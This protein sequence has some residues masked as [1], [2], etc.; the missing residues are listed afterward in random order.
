MDTKEIIDTLEHR[1]AWFKNPDYA[2]TSFPGYL[3]EPLAPELREAAEHIR[4]LEAERDVLQLFAKYVLSYKLM[5]EISDEDT[6]HTEQGAR[7]WPERWE[8]LRKY[9][10]AALRGGE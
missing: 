8:L 10:A 4:N 9:A 2:K 5:L 3:V 6:D 7:V 1:A